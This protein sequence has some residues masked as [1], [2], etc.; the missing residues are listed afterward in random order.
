MKHELDK[1]LFFNDL[2]G[3]LQELQNQ[4][5]QVSFDLSPLYFNPQTPQKNFIITRIDDRK[6]TELFF[7][8]PLT[9]M[10]NSLYIFKFE[11]INSELLKYERDF[12]YRLELRRH[13]VN[14]CLYE[15]EVVEVGIKF[16]DQVLVDQKMSVKSLMGGN[17]QLLMNSSYLDLLRIMNK[18]PALT[19]TIKIV[20]KGQLRKDL[21][22]VISVDQVLQ[23][24]RNTFFR[25][26]DYGIFDREVEY[27]TSAF[28]RFKIIPEELQGDKVLA[29][30]SRLNLNNFSHLDF[31]DWGELLF[32]F[33]FKGNFSTYKR[34][35][36]IQAK[37]R[38]KLLKK[39]HPWPV[40]QVISI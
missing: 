14:F 32:T 6:Q 27:F 33:S 34:R 15:D 31:F 29:Y 36:R 30:L 35:L 11:Q 39:Q 38:L 17:L 12:S 13:Y 16:K 25:L 3:D 19:L 22:Y 2:L 20:Q 4:N 10:V 18:G 37:Q 24:C 21:D 8:A 9:E 7:S 1:I 28:K 23:D 5:D 26:I 40:N